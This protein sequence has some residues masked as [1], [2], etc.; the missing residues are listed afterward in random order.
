MK[1]VRELGAEVDGKKLVQGT[2][3]SST[4]F[5][6]AFFFSTNSQPHDSYKIL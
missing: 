1:L 3:K 5:V 2:K 4:F 6:I